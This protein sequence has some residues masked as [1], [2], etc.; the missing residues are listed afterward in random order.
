MSWSQAPTPLPDR[1]GIEGVT[2]IVSNALDLVGGARREFL[3]RACTW[4]PALRAEVDAL[5]STS[6]ATQWESFLSVPA[7]EQ[8]GSQQLGASSPQIE[9]R[10]VPDR[11]GRYRIL[12]QLGEGGMG[13]VYLAEQNEPVKRRVALKVIRVLHDANLRQR[14]AAECQ[15]LARLNHPNIA[16][17]YEVG[18]TDDALPYVAMERVEGLC[19]TDG[20]DRANSTVEERLRLFLGVCSGIKH[21]HEKGVLHCDLKPSNVLVARLDGESVA[22]VIDFGIARALDEPLLADSRPTQELIL[23]SPPYISPEAMTA[24]G[25]LGLDTRTDVYSLGLLLYELLAGALPFE[26]TGETPWSYLHHLKE[27]GV[28]APSR[29]LEQL[30]PHRAEPIAARRRVSVRKLTGRLKGD[31]DAIVLKAIDFDPSRRYGTPAELA[32]DIERHITHRPIE[33]RSAGILVRSLCFGRRHAGGVLA[34]G[35]LF[36]ALAW[37]FAARTMEAGR[38]NAEAN[39]AR[40]A[41]EESE[42][43]RQFMVELFQGANPERMAG[44][45]VSVR[46]LLD[47]GAESLRDE[48]SEQPLVRARFLQ[49]IGSIFV[50][51]AEFQSATDLITEAYDIRRA[52][53]PAE[54]HEVIESISSL[55]LIYRH[56]GLF[57]QA[58]PLLRSVLEARQG[59]ADVHPELLAQAHGHLGNLFWQQERFEG[60]EVA[61]RQALELRSRIAPDMKSGWARANEAESANN[62]GVLLNFMGRN[63]EARPFMNQ[64]VEA[65]RQELGPLH[66]RF[67]GA[68][69]NLG[70]IDRGLAT[71]ANAEPLFREAV[72][73]WEATYGP[74][75]YR[76][77]LGR[78]NLVHELLRGHRWDE[79]ISEAESVVRVAEKLGNNGDLIKALRLLGDAQ[80]RSGRHVDSIDTYRRACEIAESELG[81]EHQQVLL[82]QTQL[83]QALA[84]VGE[85]Q[86]AVEMLENLARLQSL[87]LEI[88]HSS[89]LRTERGLGFVFYHSSR[90]VQAERHYRRSLEGNTAAHGS[91][92]PWVAQDLH[93]LAKAVAAQGRREEAAALFSLAL[94]VRQAHF[95][96]EHGTVADSAH[97]LA[98][99]EVGL[100][101]VG[102]ARKLL[103]QAV[104]I[105]KAIYPPD[106]SDLKASVA[107][108]DGLGG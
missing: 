52:H 37:G 103:R 5:L 39:R 33:A 92:H 56:Q 99:V 63:S 17:M 43:V 44:N 97:E 24:A 96:D 100:G 57:D 69:N 48:L 59:D 16:A 35:L 98:K 70:L 58:E 45:T 20:C 61:H 29:R 79:A 8:M 46:E 82:S 6:E 91:H 77:I 102:P 51:L 86:T 22:K 11:I 55:G 34:A 3:D 28:V 101:R 7:V 54:D 105:R 14:F 10:E 84:R 93:S 71:W 88:N 72:S 2:D 9:P 62:L 23:G 78:H 65:F 19:I 107:A 4:N 25:R 18:A 66:P 73:I 12:E 38:A 31:L 80:F 15:A 94:E 50:E 60:A 49:T 89:R 67:A 74:H 41:L 27:H 30:P 68:L 106:D 42:Q 64:A 75:H 104:V 1:P 87:T 26:T 76:P 95:G 32:A 21:A 85:A 13:S 40:Q 47:R 83:A 81:A 53:L 108:L 36:V 90:F